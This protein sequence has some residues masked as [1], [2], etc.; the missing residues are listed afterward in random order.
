MKYIYIVRTTNAK[1]MSSNRNDFYYDMSDLP[2]SNYDNW[3]VKLSVAFIPVENN[4]TSNALNAEYIEI[5]SSLGRPYI[6]DE[7]DYEPCIGILRNQTM[8]TSTIADRIGADTLLNN[9][10]DYVVPKETLMGRLQNVRFLY[11]DFMTNA[12]LVHSDSSQLEHSMLIFEFEGI[13]D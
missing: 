6:L 10:F 13:N 2:V 1:N 9:N 4:S 12:L 7:S 8:T 11:F 5:R 3:R